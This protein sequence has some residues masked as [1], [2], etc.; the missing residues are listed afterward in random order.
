M[1]GME[2][3]K[4]MNR[5]DYD[6][7]NVSTYCTTSIGT[8][9]SFLLILTRGDKKWAHD[10][11]LKYATPDDLF[12]D[13]DI[14]TLEQSFSLYS[15]VQFIALI[16][17]MLV[18]FGFSSNIRMDKFRQYTNTTVY[19]TATCVETGKPVYF[20][21][22]DFPKMKVSDAIYASCAIPFIYPP[23]KFRGNLYVDGALTDSYPM[24]FCKQLPNIDPTKI[25]GFYLHSL[26]TVATPT[27]LVSYGRQIMTI[28]LDRGNTNLGGVGIYAHPA[29]VLSTPAQ[30][31][32]CPQV[33]DHLK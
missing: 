30:L 24:T 25:L 11:F 21:P 7:S 22:N 27:D 17:M 13:I 31:G 20:N 12:T 2:I 33:S 5:G 32:S 9:I 15:P 3:L 1:N 18:K 6:F 26:Q 28:L 14:N 10:L 19:W 4:E 29:N 8:I 23:L 16:Q